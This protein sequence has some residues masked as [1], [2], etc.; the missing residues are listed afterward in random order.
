M[1]KDKPAKQTKGAAKKNAKSARRTNE[2]K[3]LTAVLVSP[4]L[5]AMAPSVPPAIASIVNTIVEAQHAPTKIEPPGSD[6][7]IFAQDWASA[8]IDPMR[9]A[10]SV[11]RVTRVVDE[12]LLRFRVPDEIKVD[13]RPFVQWILAGGMTREQVDKILD[14]ENRDYFA[15]DVLINEMRK[16]LPFDAVGQPS[17]PRKALGEAGHPVTVMSLEQLQNPSLVNKTLKLANL[18]TETPEL[19]TPIIQWISTNDTKLHADLGSPEYIEVEPTPKI[20]L[21]TD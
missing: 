1:A 14:E 4:F 19:E 21:E 12:A 16:V 15:L 20:Q 9:R 8:G 11:K 18:G 10:A 7:F 13:S 17:K 5:V 3:L 6:G 2:K